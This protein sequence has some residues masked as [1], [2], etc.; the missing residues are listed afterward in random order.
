MLQWY[1]LLF[2][3][4]VVKES[5]STIWD[6]ITPW[7]TGSKC[8]CN[9][10]SNRCY[11]DEKLYEKTGHGGHCLDCRAN[12][13]GA[14]CETCKENYYLREDGYCMPCNCNPTGSRSLQCNAEGKCQCHFGVAG[15]KCDHCETNFY[16]FSSH[17]C[18]SCG[19][20]EMGS[21][22][23][24]PRCD[25]Y[26]GSC[27][28]KENVEGKRCREC[29]PGFFNLEYQNKFGCTPCFCFG[30]SSS[31]KSATG[32]SKYV[33]ESSFSRSDEKWT[34][35]NQMRDD[36]NLK[37]DPYTRSIGV[38]AFNDEVIYFVA[39]RRF[40]GDQRAS[41]NQKLEF[42]LRIND[43]RAVPSAAD[44]ILE[45]GGISVTNTIFSQQN[46]VPSVQRQKFSFV[47]HEHP[48]YGWQ[49]R[50]SS[51]AFIS[52]LNNLTSIRI[53]GIY[54]YHGEGFLDDVKL[55]TALRGVAGMPVHWIESCDCP[56]G[57]V[58]QF[59]ESCAPGFRHSPSLGGSFMPCVPC[60]CNNHASICDSETGKCICQHNTIGE[61]CEMCAKGYY[62]NALAGTPSD[63]Q[64]C[65]C[66]NGGACIQVEDQ[67]TMCTECP[68]G[69]TGRRCESCADGYFGDPLG[70][71]GPPS[72]CQKCECNENIDPNAIGNCNTTTGAC[73]K[74]IYNTGGRKCEECLPGFYGN[75]LVLPKG[76]CKK[77]ECYVVGTEEDSFGAPICDQATGACRC[78][79]NV[80]GQNCDECEVG[81]FNLH[82]GKGCQACQCD[83][84]GSLNTSCDIYSGQCYC[85]PYVTGPRCDHCEY[86]KY[87]FSITGCESCDCDQIGSRD[88][89]CDSMGQCP[90]LENVEGQKCDRCKENKF[91]RRRGCIDCP[92]CYNLV[93]KEARSHTENLARLGK[94]L[95][96]IESR[97]TVI[98]DEEFPNE[99]RKVMQEVR[100]LYLEVRTATGSDSLT[101]KVRN[102]ETRIRDI[103]LVFSSVDENIFHAD[104]KNSVADSNL[105]HADDILNETE[106]KINEIDEGFHNR[107]EKTLIAAKNQAEI[108]GQHSKMM[109]QIAQEAREL[110][111]NIDSKV[112]RIIL[113]A[114]EA[115]NESVIAYN[116]AKNAVA[117]QTKLV[118]A[119][120]QLRNRLQN[121]EQK[122]NKSK[123][124]TKEVSDK[125][126]VVKNNALIL[127]SE[128]ENLNI[129]EIDISG[130]QKKVKMLEDD[131]YKIANITSD[132]FRDSESL[133]K[134]INEQSVSGKGLLK[135]AGVQHEQLMKMRNDLLFWDTQAD[136][137][138]NLWNEIL[139]GAESNYKLLSEFDTKTQK[140][141]DE[142]EAALEKIG[143]I[144]STIN[145]I[146]QK[147]K[148]AQVDMEKA[149]MNAEL[150]LQKAE[151]ADEMAKNASLKADQIKSEAE[152]LFKNTTALGQ[153]AGLMFDRVQNTEGELKNLLDKF[154][155]N[156]SLVNDAKE[157]VGRAGKDTDDVSKKVSA[158]LFD[159]EEIMTELENS[160]TIEESHVDRLEEEIMMAEEKLKEAKLEE[161]LQTLQNE[162]KFQTDLIGQ[163][164]IK[165]AILQEEVENIEEI[166]EALPAGCYRKIV[167]E[168]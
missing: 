8:N 165:I 30:H 110:A 84:I 54:N 138:I 142:A 97:P 155:S 118:T 19:C 37:Y 107:A 102:I 95:D 160:P 16:D 120:N 99:L 162:H 163:Y 11:F 12:R 29:K 67:L 35:N 45:G 1:Y 18:K 112:N 166:I 74:C 64:P 121:T 31:C 6:G 126:L 147:S 57:Y 5:K 140:N 139:D 24:E 22:G 42:T 32:Y 80:V 114:K 17:G 46:R 71:F 159:I 3:F 149:K 117:Q 59:C 75:A 86:K 122:L 63:C 41:Y 124:W 101:E 38:K 70:R 14:S 146:L 157:K 60:D 143:V 49:P 152:L 61:N 88:L 151:K 161:K 73:L 100:Q 104:T 78:K 58:G 98:A 36:V 89:Q 144:E 10:Y 28:C 34:A 72:P 119:I 131:A 123:E 125:T 23:N 135:D 148:Y 13:D 43:N 93:Q 141:K 108:A 65:G 9:G 111:D 48:D 4:L 44:I 156:T 27:Y 136:G 109:T 33:I 96:E 81:Y 103:S 168:P 91:D 21:F 94:I 87:G 92:E 164:K 154:K 129:P 20:S 52:L 85:R 39:P 55:E 83:A 133:R 50:L 167:L 7:Y 77:C 134:N 56:A 79:T 130:L 137:V 153:E 26:S 105:E 66:P 145:D 115:R 113:L 158:L 116:E 76:D 150:A 62:G 90:C 132:L 127:L 53:K 25:A 51:R 106:E 47:L 128:V 68:L 40:L 69:Y 15:D 82:N 2:V